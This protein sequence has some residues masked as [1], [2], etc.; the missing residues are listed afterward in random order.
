MLGASG[1]TSET[2]REIL[3][4]LERVRENMLSL[5]DDIWLGIDHNDPE[6]LDAGFQ[7]KKQYN[8]KMLAFDRLATDV[9]ELV[10][11]YTAVRIEGPQTERVN[12]ET[13]RE[14]NE[15]LILDLDK[16]EPHSISESLTYKRPYGF[17][18]CGEAFVD[19]VCW[20]R[21]LELVCH[22]LARRDP[23][24][25]EVLPDSPAF[26]SNRGNSRFTRDPSLLRAA[27]K[28]TES[29]YVECH[30]SANHI[31]DFIRELLHHFAIPESDLAIYL[32]QD[33]DAEESAGAAISAA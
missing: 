14:K 7:F 12:S 19:L 17:K 24:R 1:T 6:A 20:R 15:R 26:M 16:S 3:R 32:R 31:R 29:V 8:Q 5:S 13:E 22:V 23:R 25:F 30:M 21:V 9:S 27:T 28:V 18:L 10:Q 33:R 2:I 4:D 11:K